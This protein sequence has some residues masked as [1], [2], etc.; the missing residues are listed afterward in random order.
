MRE[1]R[2]P[3]IAD[4]RGAGLFVGMEFVEDDALT[5]ASD[6]TAEVVERMRERGVLLNKLG[7]WGNALKIRPPMV[8]TRDNADLFVDTLAEVLEGMA[9]SEIDEALAAFGGHSATADQ[10]PRERRLRGGA[11]RGARGGAAA[12]ARLPVASRDPLGTRLDAR[13]WPTPGSPCPT[14]LAGPVALSTGRLATAVGWVEGA[15]LG[16]GGVALPGT[17]AP[18]RPRGFA[19]SAKRSRGCTTPPTR[20]RCQPGSSA[21]PGIS[22][23]FSA[24]RR[25]G[26]GSGRTRRSPRPSAT[27]CWPPAPGPAP[28]SK[29]S[30]P[31][32][33][34]SA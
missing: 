31:G 3:M 20:W 11:A 18:S 26:A 28:C 12:P 6:F 1:I 9:M 4:V 15:P 34:I 5:P 30:R 24:R 17:R 21:T 22:R 2:H 10:D 19:P 32:A 23:A 33:P 7:R 27:W 16:A 25:S 29:T 14:P 13:R 8:F